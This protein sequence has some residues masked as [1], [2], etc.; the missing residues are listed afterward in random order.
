MLRSALKTREGRERKGL[1]DCGRREG[2]KFERFVTRGIKRK[3]G[4]NVLEGVGKMK[5]R[6]TLDKR[7]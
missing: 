7:F 6:K 2:R 1:Y 3:E 5:R 4:D